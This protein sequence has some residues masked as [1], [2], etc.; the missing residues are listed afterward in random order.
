MKLID[1]T[2]K[3]DSQIRVVFAYKIKQSGV[4]E[5]MIKDFKPQIF[6]ETK[7]RQEEAV[8]ISSAA[9]CNGLM[10]EKDDQIE[11][12]LI[13]SKIIEI[14]KKLL[15]RYKSIYD[16]RRN[17]FKDNLLKVV[18]VLKCL[19]LFCTSKSRLQTCILLEDTFT[20]LKIIN[21]EFNYLSDRIEEF[22]HPIILTVITSLT[23]HNHAKDYA[24]T[25]ALHFILT[26]AQLNGLH[27]NFFEA[28][29]SIYARETKKTMAFLQQQPIIMVFLKIFQNISTIEN[30]HSTEFK[31]FLTLMKEYTQFASFF[32]NKT[33]L[34]SVIIGLLDDVEFEDDCI[35]VRLEIAKIVKELIMNCSKIS[36]MNGKQAIL[37]SLKN[38]S[39]EATKEKKEALK[40]I[41]DDCLAVFQAGMLG[42]KKKLFGEKKKQS[43]V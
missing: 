3:N 20:I 33:D 43:A 17:I 12:L 18:D 19:Y 25:D 7:S 27:E 38:L 29:G 11:K 22:S 41:Y 16:K 35:S 8:I 31:T 15:E 24:T 4:F 23:K 5:R 42:K 28:I 1:L 2:A 6:D 13:Q 14:L 26:Y 34:L 10:N 32:A 9:V 36:K 30:F 40:T 21:E 37:N 39:R